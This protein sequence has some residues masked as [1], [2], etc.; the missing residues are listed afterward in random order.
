MLWL[1]KGGSK[2]KDNDHN[3]LGFQCSPSSVQ[4][5][6]TVLARNALIKAG[7]K[8]NKRGQIH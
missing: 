6:A 4:T 7:Q 1:T 8:K 3:A 5:T 2:A